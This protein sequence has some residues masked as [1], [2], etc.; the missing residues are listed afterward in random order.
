MT[1]VRGQAP[2]LHSKLQRARQ[3]APTPTSHSYF[4][5]RLR[6][7]YLDWGNDD[8]ANLL[9]VH[10][11][12]DHCH[13]WDWL[14]QALC[15]RFHVVAPD[16]RGHGDSEWTRGSPYSILE[17]VQD[18]AQLVRQ[19][20]L[21][22]VHVVAHSLGGTI[23]SLFAGAFPEAVAR[24]VLIEGVGLYPRPETTPDER[25]RQWISANRALSA[26]A[27]RRYASVE[28]AYQR[29][30]QTN[31]HLS[32]EQAR[33][34]TV[35]GS[36]QNEDGT[37]TWKFD[38]Y[39]RTL[40]PYDIP[41]D[42]VT[43]LWQRIACPVLILNSRHGYPHRIGQDGTLRHFQNATLREIDAAGHWTH[44]DQLD[45]TLAAI[46]EFLPSPAAAGQGAS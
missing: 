37:H 18:I 3:G 16:L 20:G 27:P 42:D 26:R 11:I 8:D 39:T 25:L 19:R 31:P 13:S 44:H 14:A 34:L 7:H 41:N 30:Q 21:A 6:L 38:N 46:E 40:R 35:H 33:H 28:D 22:P 1:Q 32:P 36:N 24:L 9:L 12:H 15:R 43:A 4:S 2:S 23:A 17:Y 10:G 45:T 5:Q 29:M